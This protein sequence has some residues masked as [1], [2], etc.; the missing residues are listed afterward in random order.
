MPTS[1]ADLISL[2]HTIKAAGISPFAG[3]FK[4]ES[5]LCRVLEGMLYDQLF[6]SSEGMAWYA[7]LIAGKK[8]FADYATPMF[9]TAKQMLDEG[10]FSLDGF[11]ASLT[12]M[13]KNF[14]AG[15]I[16]MMDYSSDIYS[17]ASSE[18]CNFDV[19]LA[20]YPSTTGKNSPVLYG[21]SAVLYIPSSIK[22]DSKRYAFDTS[23]MDYLS[24]SEG[25][26][27][28]LTGWTGVPSTK[29]YQGSSLLYQEVANYIKQGT[30][31]SIL[32]FAPSQDLVK[33]L[34]TLV[35]DAV[36]SIGK[37]TSVADAI[38]TLDTSYAKTLVDGVPTT[39]Y[40]KIASATDDFSTL[41]TSYYLADKIK[42]ATSAEIALVP[43]G[44]FYRSN[45]GY[46]SK[47]DITNDTRL[48]YEKGVGSKDFITV[49]RLT[50][51]QLR[52]ELE[53]PYI[54]SIEQNQFVAASGLSVEYAPWHASGNRV[55]KV[56][57]EDGTALNDEQTYQV[58]CYAGVLDARYITETGSVH[59]ELKDPQS[60]IE[61]SLRADGEISPNIASRVKL[62]WDIQA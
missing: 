15:K 58:A 19:G 26:D 31:H 34:E 49:Y 53:H 59:S 61:A 48:F 52:D 10:V 24:T 20:P 62:D 18:G 40:E 1:S 21:S 28:L 33:P 27:A 60:F 9:E 43:S 42:A 4:Y 8:S 6:S 35:K 16:A 30:Y 36:L 23:V 50:G 56:S 57:L 47:G 32:D 41:E 37:G 11:S 39:S 5:Q 13:R 55:V 54:N 29:N 3:C 45:M 2:C 12:T 51:V 14:F 44:G 22:G 25:Q 17:L 46:F 38:A 7:D